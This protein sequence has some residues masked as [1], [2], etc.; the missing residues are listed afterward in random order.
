MNSRYKENTNG[1]TFTSTFLVL[2]LY[3][4]SPLLFYFGECLDLYF[5]FS[6]LCSNPNSHNGIKK[7][8][9]QNRPNEVSCLPF[10]CAVIGLRRKTLSVCRHEAHGLSATELRENVLLSSDFG[11]FHFTVKIRQ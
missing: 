7:I 8:K 9:T 2:K 11:E 1:L 4:A 6:T 3:S 5:V 10:S